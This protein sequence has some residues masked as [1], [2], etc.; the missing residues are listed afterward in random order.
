[1]SLHS[2]ISLTSNYLYLFMII[3]RWVIILILSFYVSESSSLYLCYRYWSNISVKGLI[4]SKFIFCGAFDNKNMIQH[5]VVVIYRSGF[6]EPSVKILHK[7]VLCS[8]RL[9]IGATFDIYLDEVEVI[10]GRVK[11]K[12]V[13]NNNSRKLKTQNKCSDLVFIIDS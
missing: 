4:D 7:D 3:N 1:M 9:Q 11:L 10:A 6:L 13:T 2:I 8:G 5:K 12:P